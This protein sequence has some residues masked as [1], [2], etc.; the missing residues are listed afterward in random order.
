MG[1]I[2]VVVNLFF[3]TSYLVEKVFVTQLSF[4]VD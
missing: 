1:A 4:C 3:Y 2:F